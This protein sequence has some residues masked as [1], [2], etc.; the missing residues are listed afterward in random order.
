MIEPDHFDEKLA[1]GGSGPTICWAA[2][3][4]RLLALQNNVERFEFVRLLA[5]HRFGK[6]LVAVLSGYDNK[7]KV[8]WTRVLVEFVFPVFIRLR[9]GI[10][11]VR[12]TIKKYFDPRAAD[13]SALRVLHVSREVYPCVTERYAGT[14]R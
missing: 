8:T 4:K 6:D 2:S 13:R 12:C 7:L 5:A 9:F 1:G 11:A 3:A 10:F 14:S